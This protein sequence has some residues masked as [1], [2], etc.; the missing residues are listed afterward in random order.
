[1]RCLRDRLGAVQRPIASRGAGRGS[2]SRLEGGTNGS[3]EPLRVTR[4]E[5]GQ[6]DHLLELVAIA[7]D[8]AEHRERLLLRAVTH[9]EDSAAQYRDP[10]NLLGP[11]CR[12]D[13]GRK[14]E[15]TFQNS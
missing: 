12:S 3:L 14:V 6:A 5:P 15:F 4:L 2:E 10:Q 9:V 1:M 13:C 11:L 7:F 8:P